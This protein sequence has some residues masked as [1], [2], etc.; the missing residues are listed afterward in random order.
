MELENLHSV[1]LCYK[2]KLAALQKYTP[3]DCAFEKGTKAFQSLDSYKAEDKLLDLDKIYCNTLYELIAARFFTRYNESDCII[4]DGIT[5]STSKR[6]GNL[7][8]PKERIHIP[9]NSNKGA[10]ATHIARG[11]E[12]PSHGIWYPLEY[13]QFLACYAS[14]EESRR[15]AVNINKGRGGV[16]TVWFDACGL[17][18]TVLTGLMDTF[19]KLKDVFTDEF[20]VC[21]TACLDHT[22]GEKKLLVLN[23]WNYMKDAAE[24][25]G[26]SG[27]LVNAHLYMNCRM[28]FVSG[29]FKR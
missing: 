16:S 13:S 1:I 22:K 21:I 20:A 6:L 28:C 19:D 25:N 7:Y 8:I 18:S 26:F 3:C 4:L 14:E 27:V 10:L 9:N 11:H 12:G 17:I 5:Q 29:V 15:R 2:E 23:L 24:K